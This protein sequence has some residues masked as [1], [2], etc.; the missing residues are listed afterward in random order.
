MQRRRL[1]RTG[2]DSSV[3]ILGGAAFWDTTVDAVERAFER[4][5]AAGVNHLDIAPQYGMAEDLAGAVLPR[6][7][8][9][10]FVACKT[11]QRTADDAR[12]ELERSLT[13][14]RTDYFDLYQLH[15]VVSDQELEAVLAPGGAGE[16]LRRAKEEGLVRAIGITGHFQ[17]VPRL[18]RT[19]VERLDL[20]T[21]MLPVNPP[22]LALPEYRS[23]FEALLDLALERD[24]GVM[25]IKAV[26]RG[27]WRSA[28]HTA[29]TWYEPHRDPAA[30]RDGVR[31]ALSFPITGFAMPGDLSLHEAALAAANEFT[32]MP[33]ADIEERI[34]AADQADAL[35]SS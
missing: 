26:A 35:V 32:P 3:A 6:Y 12:A 5:V 27:P 31:F 14:L 20:D 28:E 1:G 24:L 15:A 10:M 9:H 23:N 17:E 21:V 2:H 7:R 11:Q 30:I 16:T 25:A 4:A 19:A 29:T 33:K 8:E 18:F 34:A 13:K 22:M